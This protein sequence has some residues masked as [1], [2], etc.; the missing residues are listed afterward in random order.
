MKK[1]LALILTLTLGMSLNITAFAD[2]VGTGDRN[3]AVEGKYQNT[4]TTLP[5]YSVDITWGAM[6][7]IYTESGSKT[8]NPATH[9]YTDSITSG[10]T[11]N[12]NTVTV[13]N[14][15]NT[16]VTASFDF[17]VLADYRTV[18]GSF[19]IVSRTLG[20]GVEGAYAKADYVTATLTLDGTLAN[21]VTDY[22]KIGTVTVKI[23]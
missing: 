21:T 8:W 10:W 23:S 12:G 4:T 11:A 6:Q 5:V 14:H 22:T 16:A 3:I 15:S 7:F 20:A 9:T 1:I 13:T 2:T 17:A 19:N 18:T